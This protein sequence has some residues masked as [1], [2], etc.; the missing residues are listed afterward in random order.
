MASTSNSNPFELLGLPI[1]FELDSSFIERAYLTRLACAHPDAGGSSP[2]EIEAAMLNEART[3]LLDHEQRAVALFNVL[4]G[5]G[6]TQ[7]KDLPDGF[8]IE[9]M[10]RRQEIE[11]QIADGADE[12][13]ASWESWARAERA[14]YSAAASALFAQ[15]GDEPSDEKLTEIRVLLNAWRYIERLIEQLDPEYDP[16]KADFR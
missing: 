9:M 11:E 1:S 13:R 12:S 6:A 15:L 4:G 14:G 8:L 2:T 10:T 16:A 3:I 5:P 7:C